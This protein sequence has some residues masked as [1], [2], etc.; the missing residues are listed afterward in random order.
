MLLC[1]GQGAGRGAVNCPRVGAEA[2]LLA[3][4]ACAIGQLRVLERTNSLRKSHL[5]WVAE[6]Y[7]LTA[8]LMAESAPE[9][10]SSLSL[11]PE[12]P[13]DQV[14]DNSDY[15]KYKQMIISPA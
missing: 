12:F 1:R 3:S 13:A 4:G 9:P 11:S 15:E 6:K 7:E 8:A 10:K 14:G 2:V 5:F